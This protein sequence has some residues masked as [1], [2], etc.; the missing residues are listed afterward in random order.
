M[1]LSLLDRSRTRSGSTDADALRATPA[2]ARRAEGHGLHRF[3]V[4]EHHAVPGVVGS[5]PAVTMAAVAAATSRIRV[6]TAGIMLPNHSPFVVA[7]QLATLAALHPGRI[8]VGVGRSLG[9]TAPV[10]RALGTSDADGFPDRLAELLDWLHGRGPVTVRPQVPA[11]PVW[12]LATGSGLVTAARFG[13]PVVVTGAT[14]RDPGPLQRYRDDSPPGHARVTLALDVVVGPTDGAARA[15]LLPQAVALAR[16][17]SRGEFGPLPSPAQAAATVLSARE[18]HDVEQALDAAVFG[19]EAGVLQQLTELA[20]R[21]G[22]V[23]LL[24]SATPHAPEREQEN[25]ARLA[26]LAPRVPTAARLRTAG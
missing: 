2:R 25:D 1:L 6:G 14:L 11:P 12:L 7:E 17:R 19:D 8:D 16:A 23:E 5:A 26:R 21:T 4:A 18:Q 10:R 24:H 15:E 3:W 13:L 22:A 20:A 9:F